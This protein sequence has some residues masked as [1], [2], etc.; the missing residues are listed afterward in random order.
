MNGALLKKIYE[1]AGVKDEFPEAGEILASL[2]SPY[3]GSSWYLSLNHGSPYYKKLA[4][5]LYGG[6]YV[7]L[8]PDV[9][10]GD[11]IRLL[12][13]SCLMTG[14]LLVCSPDRSFDKA[15]AYLAVSGEKLLDLSTGK[16]TTRGAAS[17]LLEGML[18]YHA[19]AVLRPEG[20]Q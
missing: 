8:D 3:N 20:G 14:D 19:F 2:Y 16:I 10:G 6:W 13:P 7:A 15:K 17:D 9:Y 4:P 5:Y 11:R 12:K 1:K 18:G